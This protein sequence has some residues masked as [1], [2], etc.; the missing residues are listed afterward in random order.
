MKTCRVD[1]RRDFIK[2]AMLL[3]AGGGLSGALPASIQRA[4]AIDPPPGAV[5]V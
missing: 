3:A 2:K 5:A 4:F 1:S